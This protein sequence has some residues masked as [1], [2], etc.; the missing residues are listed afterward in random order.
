[1]ALAGTVA[2]VLVAFAGRYGY[3]RDELYFLAA[4]DHLAP[5]FPD[6]GPLTPAIAA[7]AN[8]IAPGSLTVLRIPAAI[9]TALTIVLSGHI[10]RELGGSWRAQ[11]ITGLC[12][13]VTSVF[14]I[15]GHLL[16]TTTFDLLAW[17]AATLIFVRLLRGGDRRLWL[18]LG[19]VFGIALLNKPLIAFLAAGLLIGLLVVGPREVLRSRWLV[20]GIALALALWSP[21]LAWQADHG[22]PQLEVASSIASG[23][24]GTSEPRWAFLPFQLLLVSPVLAPVWIAGLW[25]LLTRASLRRYRRWRSAG[26]SSSSPSSSREASRIT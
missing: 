6:Q 15:T 20:G 19:A 13:S 7:I 25:A 1:M 14:V 24:S 26:C 12:A 23:G 5:S 8:A 4:A 10:C 22:W 2:I 16:S 17:T 9:A 11:V 21:W 3:H 18:L